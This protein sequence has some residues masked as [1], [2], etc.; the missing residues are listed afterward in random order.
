[1]DIVQPEPKT[2]WVVLEMT[3]TWGCQ[4]IIFDSINRKWSVG[5][6]ISNF[7]KLLDHDFRILHVDASRLILIGF[8]TLLRIAKTN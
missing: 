2:T 4:V 7:A 6:Y 8:S 5:Q 3:D 1:M